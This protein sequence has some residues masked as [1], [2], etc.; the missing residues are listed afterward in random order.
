MTKI[1]YVVAFLVI[2][3]ILLILFFAPENP[4]DVRTRINYQIS[5]GNKSYSGKNLRHH[6]GKIL[7]DIQ[8]GQTVV[9][10]PSLGHVIEKKIE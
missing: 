5:Q 6:D 1:E 7:L 4:Q 3:L 8:N 10:D 9:I 2:V